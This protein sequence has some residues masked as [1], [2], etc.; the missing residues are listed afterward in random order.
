MS[1]N[2]RY[3]WIH[4]FLSLFVLKPCLLLAGQILSRMIIKLPL[5]SQLDPTSFISYPKLSPC[6]FHSPWENC[7]KILALN[8]LEPDFP[9]SSS[10]FTQNTSCLQNTQSLGRKVL[11]LC[12]KWLLLLMFLINTENQIV[13]SNVR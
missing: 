9:T 1:K 3:L 11:Y 4:W 8:C 6:M 5:H 10:P 13:K 2:Q 7:F 12:K